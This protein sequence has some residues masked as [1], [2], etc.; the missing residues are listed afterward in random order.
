MKDKERYKMEMEV[1][2]ERLRTG[3][4]T[5]VQHTTPTPSL[6][7]LN[8]SVPLEGNAAAHVDENKA[9]SSDKSAFE[10]RDKDSDFGECSQADMELK[11]VNIEVVADEAFDLQTR[12]EGVGHDGKRPGGDEDA[13]DGISV[14]VE[15]IEQPVS[16]ANESVAVNL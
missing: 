3:Q 14:R 7:D 12:P 9:V 2:R 8:C 1:Y 11:N 5:T 4:I 13:E 15:G 10:S 16:N 6:T